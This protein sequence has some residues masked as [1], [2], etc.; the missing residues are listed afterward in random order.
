MPTYIHENY[1][2][3]NKIKI[4]K[5]ELIFISLQSK[6]NC[7]YMKYK[8]I[9]FTAIAFWF[10]ATLVTFSVK[11]NNTA[12]SIRIQM[13]HLEGQQL[14]Q[15]HSNLCRLAAGEDSLDNE[16]DALDAYIKEARRQKDIEAEGEARSMQV[17]CFYNYDLDDKLKETLPNH[18]EFMRKNALWDCYYNSWNTLIQLLI[19]QNNLQTALLEASKMYDDAKLNNSNYGIG[20]SAYCMGSIYQTMQRFKEAKQ[21]LEESIEALNK[22]E[23]ISLL[24]TSYNTLGET[25]D[26]LGQYEELRSMALAWK[27]VLD[28]YKER[29]EAM[30]YTPSLNGQYLYCTLA[31]TVAELEMGDYKKANKLLSEAKDFAE[32]RN[33]VWHYKFLQ[34]QTRYYAATKQYDKAIANNIE[35]MATLKLIG[36]SISLLSV[37]LQQAD[38]LL[39]TKQYEEAAKLYKSIIPRK[40]KLRNHE[41]TTQLDELRT[42]YKVDKLTLKNR[43]ITNRVYF[44][45]ISSILLLIVVVLYIVYTISLRRKN[46]VLF[47]TFAQSQKKEDNLYAVKTN[48]EDK[49]LTS[50]EILYKNLNNLIQSEQLYKDHKVNRTDVASKLNTNHTYLTDAIKQCSDGLTFTEFIN[51]YRLRHAA[52]LLTTKPDLNINE[53]GEASGFNSRSTYNRLFRSH[54]GMSPS[55]FRDIA[56]EKKMI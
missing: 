52:T 37:E 31:A 1:T 56:K 40:D 24:I 47:E 42:I 49:K 21:S 20:V 3:K 23:D 46:R 9:L 34:I 29:V 41:L 8:A 51:R 54:Y 28:N 30:G 22:E 45:F 15:A 4:N 7:T 55:E 33:M 38:L 48:V 50:E 11:A 27:A 17:M 10:T 35:N 19:Y 14:L 39:A 25:L 18:L 53:V 16:L 26:G 13:K 5:I 44:F 12:D 43:I 6:S 32:G 36:D 2:E